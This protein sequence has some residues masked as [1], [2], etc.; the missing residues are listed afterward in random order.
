VGAIAL[1]KVIAS[2]L[3]GVS[4]ADPVVLGGMAVVMFAVAVLAA[5]APALRASRIDPVEALRTE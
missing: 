5:S 2:Q 4:A 3:I 1:R